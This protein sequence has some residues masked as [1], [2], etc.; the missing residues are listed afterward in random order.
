VG[1]AEGGELGAAF[2]GAAGDEEQGAGAFEA[3]F[4][5]FPAGDGA[6]QGRAVAEASGCAVEA[7]GGPGVLPADGCGGG[8]PFGGV[9]EAGEHGD[10]GGDGPGVGVVV[11]V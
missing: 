3:G 2:R 7:G 5:A 10:L 8:Q 4:D 9:R 1:A 11:P 6:I